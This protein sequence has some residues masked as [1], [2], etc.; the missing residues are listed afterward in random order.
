M[1][2]LFPSFVPTGFIAFS[3]IPELAK[4][5][6]MFF[7]LAPVVS[8]KFA[9]GTISK[10][11]LLSAGLSKVLETASPARFLFSDLKNW[12]VEGEPVLSSSLL[13]VESGIS[14]L[15]GICYPLH[16]YFQI[17]GNQRTCIINFA[18]E[19]C[20]LMVKYQCR[21]PPITRRSTRKSGRGSLNLLG[22]PFYSTCDLEHR[23]RQEMG[24]RRYTI[25]TCLTLTTL[26]LI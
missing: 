2:L 15:Y 19:F 22:V 21:S 8:T 11:L 14:S 6:K 20:V 3:R 17:P 5:I 9:T 10:F 1:Q 26:T 4:K 13:S 23:S 12:P 18:P 7:A 16:P 24:D 25:P